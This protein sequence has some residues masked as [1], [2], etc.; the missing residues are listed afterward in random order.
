MFFDSVRVKKKIW[1]FF[2]T[3][4]LSGVD[5]IDPEGVGGLP[6][7]VVSVDSGNENF[8]LVVINK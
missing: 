3:D 4:R 1:I 8:A 2:R 7:D 6:G 5:D